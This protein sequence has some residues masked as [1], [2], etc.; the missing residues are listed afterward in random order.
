MSGYARPSGFKRIDTNVIIQYNIE[1][2]S[3]ICTE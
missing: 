1:E 2:C 3:P